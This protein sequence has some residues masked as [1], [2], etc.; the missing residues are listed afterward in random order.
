M[1]VKRKLF[2]PLALLGYLCGCIRP[3]NYH[4]APVPSVY[5]Y[6]YHDYH[7]PSGYDYFFKDTFY[8]AYLEYDAAGRPFDRTQLSCATELIKK[9]RQVDT[10][11]ERKV[12]VFVFVHGWKNNA[13]EASGNV[14]GFRRVLNHL[15]HSVHYTAREVPVIGIYIG[16]PGDMSKVA[17]NLTF[18]NRESV[19][20]SVGSGDLTEDLHTI[21]VSTKG[22]NYDGESTVV[23]IGHSFGGLVLERAV[24]PIL[25]N[26]VEQL[27][28]SL[29]LRAPADMILLLNEAAPASQGAPFIKELLKLKVQYTDGTKKFPLIASMTSEGDPATKIAF[30]GGEYISPNR[31]PT[32][33]CN[34]GLDADC[35]GGLDTFGQ[36]TSLPYNLLTTANMVGLQSHEFVQVGSLAKCTHVSMSLHRNKD[37]YCIQPLP[38][39]VQVANTTPYWVMQ[40]PEAFVPDHGSIFRDQ[41]IT[42]IRAILAY[43]GIISRRAVNTGQLRAAPTLAAQPPPT[44]ARPLLQLG[45]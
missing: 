8:E 41:V 30:P 2:L 20:D 17:K 4:Q 21:L 40:M 12:R 18:W 44:E 14:W 26:R 37:F 19:A 10:G 23:L 29:K 25:R 7:D 39:S 36:K 31:P 5:K 28:P 15:A 33:N 11:R 43:E 13:S 32:E 45:P 38:D 35:Q 9:L 34:T 42:V 6:D 24:L 16:W 3:Q 27:K 1:S 22:D